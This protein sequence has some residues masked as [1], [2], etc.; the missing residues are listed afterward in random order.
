MV[1]GVI[2]FTMLFFTIHMIYLLYNMIVHYLVSGVCVSSMAWIFFRTLRPLPRTPW[3]SFAA[4]DFVPPLY[5]GL[6]MVLHTTYK[7]GDDWGMVNMTASF[8]NIT[9][10]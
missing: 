8:T 1:I 6:R 7:T 9:G 2:I 4:G 5:L 3:W 10:W